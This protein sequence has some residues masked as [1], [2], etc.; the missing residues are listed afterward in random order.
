MGMGERVGGL[1]P[2][3]TMKTTLTP[4]LSRQQDVLRFQHVRLSR[5]RLSIRGTSITQGEGECVTQHTGTELWG[6]SRISSTGAV[7]SRSK[8]VPRF[9]NFRSATN[10]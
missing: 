4:V 1:N 2:A 6:L 5:C 3:L 9:V 8:S 7:N 10:E